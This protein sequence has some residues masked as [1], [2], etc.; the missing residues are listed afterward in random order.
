L[1]TLAGQKCKDYIIWFGTMH[2]IKS[3]G[4]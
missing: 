3:A 2:Y 4:L 1:Y